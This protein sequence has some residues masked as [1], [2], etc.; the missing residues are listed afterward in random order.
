MGV[1]QEPIIFNY[2]ILENI[3]YGKP[4]ATNS[5]VKS[6]CELAN[7]MEFID[8]HAGDTKEELAFDDSAQALLKEMADN[9]AKV[10]ALIGQEKYDEEVKLLEECAA[11]DEKKGGF[12][13]VAG[14]VDGRE[15]AL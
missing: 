5:Q 15:E 12:Q 8:V 6:A 4:D 14:A 10:I 1:M 13:S 9:R 2:N 11:N 7:C 3:L